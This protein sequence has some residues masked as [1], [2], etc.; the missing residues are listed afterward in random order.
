MLG[1][2][3]ER[4][5]LFCSLSPLHRARAESSACALNGG[6]KK[7]KKKGGQR[8]GVRENGV[9][10]EGERESAQLKM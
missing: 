3:T 1:R 6:K 2:E 10:G 4:Q 5:P 8:R 7:K 9:N